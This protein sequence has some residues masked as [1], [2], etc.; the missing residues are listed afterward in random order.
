MTKNNYHNQ[1]FGI[2]YNFKTETIDVEIHFLLQF[3]VIF[4]MHGPNWQLILD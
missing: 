3:D 4:E 2:F 1:I